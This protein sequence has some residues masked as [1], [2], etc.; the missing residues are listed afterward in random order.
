MQPSDS[1]SSSSAQ[2]IATIG[3]QGRFWDVYLDFEDDPGRPDTY[4]GFLHFSA[5]DAEEGEEP[6]RTAPIIIEKSYEEAVRKARS[7]E[8][9]QLAAFLR[10]ARS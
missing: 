4:R 6:V 10:S 7:F 3:H 1:S 5:A 8:D 9:R 2:H